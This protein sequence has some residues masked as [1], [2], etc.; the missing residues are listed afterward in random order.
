MPDET[1]IFFVC[2]ENKIIHVRQFYQSF[3]GM[4]ET[5]FKAP[6]NYPLSLLRNIHQSDLK[7]GIPTKKLGIPH[8]F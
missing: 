8:N 4:L 2:R 7:I 5:D 3:Q 1:G 6:I